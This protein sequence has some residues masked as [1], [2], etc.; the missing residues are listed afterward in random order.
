M[1]SDNPRLRNWAHIGRKLLVCLLVAGG[2]ATGRA[3][4]AYIPA[5]PAGQIEVGVPAFAV[6]SPESMGL[7]TAPLD[8]HFLPDGRLA[9]ITQREIA[10]GDGTRWETFRRSADDQLRMG[11][12]VA[13]GADG[14]L[15]ASVGD[16]FSRIDFTGDARWEHSPVAA[17]PTA[18]PQ[19]AG[20]PE[21]MGECAGNWY[22]YGGS[23]S[24]LQWKPGDTPRTIRHAAGSHQVFALGADVFVSDFAS[25]HIYRIDPARGETVD[26]SPPGTK[27]TTGIVSTA[28]FERGLLLVSTTRHGLQLFNGTSLIPFSATCEIDPSLYVNDLCALGEGR[29][30]AAVDGVGI[31]IF[32]RT[33]RIVQTL[34]RTLDHRLARPQKLLRGSDGMLWAL[35]SDGVVRMQLST[36]TTDLSLMVPSSLSYAFVRRF[37]GELWIE[38]DGKALRGIYSPQGRLLHFENVPPPRRGFTNV[39]VMEDRLFAS[40]SQFIYE[41]TAG[42]WRVVMT[43]ISNAR[44]GN[45]PRT[46]RGWLYVADGEVGWLQPTAEGLRA[47]RRVTPG[48]GTIYNTAVDGAGALWLERGTGLATR[49]EFAPDGSPQVQ[50]FGLADGLPNEWIQI[51]IIDGLARIA[52]AKGILRLDPASGRF[53]QDEEFL[54]RY[55]ELVGCSSRPMRDPLGRIWYVVGGSLCVLDTQKAPPERMRVVMP[56]IAPNAIASD[57]DGVIWVAQRRNLLRYDPQIPEPPARRPRALITSVH[58]HATNRYI[59]GPGAALPAL[60]YEENS[61]TV[62]F[63]APDD[64]FIAPITFE[65][66]LEVDGENQRH[67]VSTDNVGSA[68]FHGLKEG[69]YILRVRALSGTVVGEETRLT[70]TVRP[71]WYRSP[72]ARVL[73]VAGGLGLVL[74][75]SWLMSYLERR[76]KRRLSRLV[77][78]RTRELARQVEETNARTVALQE[79]EE[80]FAKAFNDSPVPMAIQDLETERYIDAN[81]R[82]LL[83]MGYSREE[84]GGRTPAELHWP[85]E[86]PAGGHHCL[87]VENSVSDKAVRLRRKDGSLIDCLYTAHAVQIGGRPCLLSVTLDVTERRRSEVRIRRL[88]RTLAVLSD[89][90]QSI[91]R[92]RDLPRLYLDACRITVAKGGFRLAWIGMLDA[93][94]ARVQPV[95][96]ASEDDRGVG[97]MELNLAAPAQGTGLPAT[98]LLKGERIVCNDIEHD[99]SALP[100]RAEA[101]SLGYRAYAVFPF[102]S[103]GH[104]IGAI[105]IYSG[106]TG[107]FDNEELLLLD[108]LAMDISF[109]I[110]YAQTATERQEA[111]DK[112]RHLATFPE[113][114][115]NPVI[116]FSADGA[117]A[118]AN[119]AAERM[120]A[121]AGSADL[122][123]LLP[124]NTR[125]IVEQC[126]AVGQPS[127][128]LETKNGTRTISWSF[129]PIAGQQTVHCY[130]GD[131]TQRLQLEERLRQAEKMDAIGRL[132]GGVAHD[133]NN[134]LTVIMGQCALLLDSPA[135]TDPETAEA[136]ND[137]Q[138]A[139]TRAAN[140]TRQLLTFSR[141]Q[142]MRMRA[143]D[144]NDIASGVGRMLQRLIGEN[145]VLHTRLQTSNAVVE[146][147]VGMFEQVVLNLAINGRDAM[148]H[149]G[150]LWIEV[151]RVSI[152]ESTAHQHPAGRPG[153]FICLGVRDTGHGIS[154]ADLPHVFEPFFTTKEVGKGTGLGLATVHGIVDQ[155]RGWIE[156]DSLQ[157]KGTTFRVLLPLLTHEAIAEQAEAEDDPGAGGDETIL[158]VED[159]PNVRAL[160]IRILEEKGYHVIGAPDGVAALELWRQQPG[161]FD[162]L[163]TDLLMPGGVSGAQLAE[164]L[165]AEKPELP[166]IY[167]SGYRGDV[168]G[169]ELELHEGVN[170]LQKPFVPAH[171]T[172]MVRRSLGP[173]PAPQA[174][175]GDDSA[176]AGA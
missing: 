139:A 55:P 109:A 42:E 30:A 118:Y 15:Y 143:V 2:L 57:A 47:D 4:T 103:A 60:P 111:Q 65:V 149:G 100:W 101:L 16:S 3:D 176:A 94:G 152:D 87:T 27:A 167:V 68:S 44:I 112:V 62:R 69:H 174:A 73:F 116:E 169:Q 45:S 67:W 142:P 23:G 105:T 29:F 53:V 163:V 160:A 104:T 123:S 17:L 22:W 166:V 83:L 145:I 46:P 77:E 49:V 90:N 25:G 135:G 130:A 97:G 148:P 107:C 52:S 20:A 115:P 19:A 126:L 82:C 132:A 72:L 40:Y 147:D 34:D 137:I 43:G 18:E 140:L 172:R 146:G 158:V 138:T 80:R 13:V 125:E 127:L 117:L 6:H 168:I 78:E 24:L 70:F 37:R 71:P 144:I 128:R 120:A 129:Y 150:D 10:V 64:S 131:I 170:F 36:S 124:G 102:R 31:V 59:S 154:P 33:G 96:H 58:L 63:V 14:H 81:N 76:E 161:A 133:F 12:K 50:A 141:K 164:R 74:F 93:A 165:C 159:E 66:L 121:N 106:E 54:R 175:K 91:V 99:P 92:E 157:G 9:V 86:E 151:D 113:L 1:P 98:V 48:L 134:L 51:F 88:N 108:E 173:R 61:L 119:P 28:E 41:Y 110:E 122:A 8:L 11:E 162:L 171:L 136:A 5:A 39:G 32:D 26:V 79:S 7:S 156:V 153:T 95:A 56:G 84:V 85:E 35:L 75:V 38:S 114:N 21:R 155:H 89:I